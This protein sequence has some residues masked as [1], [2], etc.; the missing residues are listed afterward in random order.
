M[1][2]LNPPVILKTGSST[3]PPA[4]ETRN[5][6][7]PPPTGL[8]NRGGGFQLGELSCKYTKYFYSF[9]VLGK[10]INFPL[11]SAENYLGK[12]HGRSLRENHI[13][14]KKRWLCF[15]FQ[16]SWYFGFLRVFFQKYNL[17]QC[18]YSPGPETWALLITVQREG[19]CL[20]G[21]RCTLTLSCKYIFLLLWPSTFLL[22][23]HVCSSGEEIWN[24]TR[25]H[26]RP[27][28]NHQQMAAG[29]LREPQSPPCRRACAGRGH[30]VVTDLGR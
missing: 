18:T 29:G 28:S 27:D 30:S 1:S 4:H 14:C 24:I 19:S 10:G 12:L 8:K 23:P 26:W 9:L 6:F 15:V 2:L 5:L 11:K 21:P 3:S 13:S 25:S 16:S 7:S 22:L 20:P 17:S